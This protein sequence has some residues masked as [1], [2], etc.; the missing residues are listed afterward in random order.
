MAAH[1]KDLY[2]DTLHCVMVLLV[3]LKQLI[4]FIIKLIRIDPAN[5]DWAGLQC[6]VQTM[7]LLMP[8]TDNIQ[9]FVLEI[10]L[11]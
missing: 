3:P 9:Q 11:F 8:G 5:E 1:I 6:I 7:S 4:F 2:H 10:V